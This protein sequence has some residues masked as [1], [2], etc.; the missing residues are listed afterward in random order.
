MFYRL[1]VFT[2]VVLAG[3]VASC[4]A[5]QASAPTGPAADDQVG[6]FV[7]QELLTDDVQA[8]RRFY[9]GLFGWQFEE[10]KRLG[11]PYT[12]VRAGGQPVAGITAVE[13]QK[14]DEPVAQ[15]LSYLLVADV[16]E[17]A[18]NFKD[19]GGEILVAPLSLTGTARAAL[20]T[21]P[22]GAPLGLVSSDA[23]L[24]APPADPP[25]G[26]FFW[27]DYFAKDV[28]ASL[29]FYRQFPG[30]QAQAEGE[31]DILHYVFRHGTGGQAIAG[32]IPIGDSPVR[33][34]W[35]PYVRV[36]DPAALARRASELGGTVL[37]E[38]RSDVREG[39]LAIVADPN[40]GALA[41]QKWPI[42]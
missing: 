34:N 16:D 12:L 30:Y 28:E 3:L 22:A 35:L 13:R 36:G 25:M 42:S 37:L 8:A 26:R 33:P 29:A 40:G 11:E 14:P 39:S 38:P 31:D 17:A 10:T 19:A 1:R 27:R 6:R 15:W 4:S 9:G 23:E 5:R 24:P 41:L 2:L 21:D 20:V 7:W 18:Q 32:L